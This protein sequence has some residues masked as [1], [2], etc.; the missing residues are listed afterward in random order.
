MRSL[1]HRIWTLIALLSLGCA[2]PD[3]KPS[4]ADAGSDG[5]SHWTPP[6]RDSSSVVLVE[7][8]SVTYAGDTWK[9]AFYRNPAYEC[10]L[11]GNYT[12]LVVEPRNNPGGK[13]PL[14]IYLHGGGVG[15]FDNKGKYY[16]VKGQTKETY[17]KEESLKD[18]WDKWVIRQHLDNGKGKLR[19][20]LMKRRIEQGY[21]L[22]LPS[23]CDHD[24]Y[25]GLGTPYPNNPDKPKARVNG[26][27]A[28]M[29]AV[30]YTVARRQTTH[31]FA[32]GTSAGSVGVYSLAT[33]FA[34]EGIQLTG[35][36]A[37]SYL[38]TPRLLPIYKAFAGTPGYPFS[39]EFNPQSVIDKVGFFV[40]P[41]K[42]AYPEARL[43]AG[44]AGV[45][46][47][48]IGGDKDRFCGGNKAPIAEASAAGLANCH[49][50]WDGLRQVIAKQSNT[51]HQVSLI[52]GT[53]YPEGGHGITKREGP[54][55]DLVDKFI[56][57]ALKANPPPPFK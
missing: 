22:L 33:S 23:M 40:D 36:V 14:W 3:G 4:V 17:N 13:A 34:A 50:L 51:P 20:A 39:S 28:T 55:I 6:N 5:T 57:K 38:I 46:M 32:H 9:I 44:F 30:E 27:Q 15:Y 25:S 21:R 45:P 49:W 26:L 18:L 41:D 52:D 35:I 37:D 7:E 8:K 1:P 16:A 48:F 47:L 19:D 56:K 24:L 2:S 31:V 10:G 11:K 53:G 29:A 12:F 43:S 54:H 42:L